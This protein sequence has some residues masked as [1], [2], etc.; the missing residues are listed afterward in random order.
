MEIDPNAP[1]AMQAQQVQMMM[2]G[3]QGGPGGFLATIDKGVVMTMSQ[4]TP[5]MT[6]ALES[7]LGKKGLGDN[8]DVKS[9]GDRLPADRTFELFIGVR[10]IIDMVG[11]FVPGLAEK[12]PATLPPIAL[13]AVTSDG[14]T[15]LRIYV[16]VQVIK[17]LKSLG[18]GMGG[19][20]G[21]GEKEEPPAKDEGGKAPRF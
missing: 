11:G 13:G 19:Q 16:P 10:A 18:D 17:T 5:L 7:A 4:N 20:E 6:S 1:T 12:A 21:E 8:A 14:G 3:A 2:F 15:H 9:A